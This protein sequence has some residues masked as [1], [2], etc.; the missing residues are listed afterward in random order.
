MRRKMILRLKSGRELRFTCDEYEIGRLKMTGELT[1]YEFT[2][3][4]GEYPA[5]ISLDDVEAIIE[6]RDEE[7]P[8]DEQQTDSV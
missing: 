1:R 3:V 8:E 5:Y 2:N 6:V 4:A 7:E